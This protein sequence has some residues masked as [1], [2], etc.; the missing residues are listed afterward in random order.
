M[1]T[2]GRLPQWRPPASRRNVPRAGALT[3]HRAESS[4]TSPAQRQTES[5]TASQADF[6]RS[7]LLVSGAGLLPSRMRCTTLRSLLVPMSR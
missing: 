5:S 6:S 7:N 3:Q 1:P 4:A 2:S